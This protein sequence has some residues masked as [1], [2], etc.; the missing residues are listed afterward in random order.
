VSE[1]GGSIGRGFG[2]TAA[3]TIG[4]VIFGGMTIGVGI[5]AI[6][7]LGIGLVQLAWILPLFFSYR[8][9]GETETAY[10]VLLAAGI[11]FL[12]NASCWGFLVTKG[13]GPMH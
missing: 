4:A 12:L 13:V 11:T 6:I 2:I 9:K 7:L 8:R 10:G 5:G 3:I 1:H